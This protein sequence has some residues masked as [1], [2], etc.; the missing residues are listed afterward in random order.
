MYSWLIG[1]CWAALALS[2]WWLIAAA[3]AFAYFGYAARKEEAIMVNTFPREYP[4]YQRRTKMIV[5]FLF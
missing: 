5:P 1:G 3:A 4:E 2:L